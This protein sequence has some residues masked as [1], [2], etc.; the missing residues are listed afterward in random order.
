MTNLTVT[1]GAGLLLLMLLFLLLNRWTPLNGKQSALVAGLLTCT[2]YLPFPLLRWP[3]ADVVTIHF[4][5]YLVCAYVL[6]IIASHRDTLRREDGSLPPG[7]WFHWGPA[8]IVIFFVVIIAVDT[9]FVTLAVNGVPKGIE[10]ELLPA[11]LAVKA[12]NTEF[13]GVVHDHY[14]QKETA[15]NDY[16]QQVATQRKRG[17][18][19]RKGWLTQKP[20]AGQAEVFQVRVTD[21]D[22]RPIGGAKVSGRFVRPSDSRFDQRFSMTQVD[23]GLYRVTVMLPQPGVWEL[24]LLVRQGT[25]THRLTATTNIAASATVVHD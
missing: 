17:W 9:V 4:A 7:K 6:G 10:K 11:R 15:F 22:G 1:L 20:F 19:V 14:Y 2:A 16:L 13:P 24:Q 25:L 23:D 12:A 5:I 8:A 3:G 21:R 18:K